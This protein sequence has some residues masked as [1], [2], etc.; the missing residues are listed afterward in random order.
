LHLESKGL[1]T[2]FSL[3]MF[4]DETRRFPSLGKMNSTCPALPLYCSA[5]RCAALR[6]STARKLAW[7]LARKNVG[8]RVAVVEVEEVAAEA[9]RAASSSTVSRLTSSSNSC[10]VLSLVPCCC[11]C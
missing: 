7:L 9:A 5:T 6:S 8:M 10:G 4:K 1:E 2:G 11:C 3:D